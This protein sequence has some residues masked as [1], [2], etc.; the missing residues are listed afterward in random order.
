MAVPIV[1]TSG[2]QAGEP[3][4]IDNVLAR[5]HLGHIAEYFVLHNR[6]IAQRVDDS[7]VKV[8]LNVP[9]MFRRSRGYAPAPVTLPKG[10]E[11]GP[12]VLAM[13]GELK[14]T[15]CFLKKGQAFLSHHIG[16]LEEAL[17]YANYQRAL[18]Q[19]QQLFGLTPEVI[20]V[21]RHPEY[22]SSKLG[23]ERA[24]HA[25]LPVIEVQH[26]HAHLAACLADHGIPLMTSP[27]LGVILDGLGYGEDHTIWGGEFLA[28]DYHHVTRLGTFKPVAMLGGSQAIKEPWRNT[29]AHLV[30]GMGWAQFA[31]NYHGLPLFHYLEQ[32]PRSMLDQMLAKNVN[33]PLASSCG[34]LFDAVAAAMG[35]CQDRILYEGQAAMELEAMVNLATLELED[36][37]VAY[38]FSISPLRGFQPLC[39]E[40]LAMWE[41]FLGDLA[42]GTPRPVM[43]A[44]FHKGLANAI[45]AMVNICSQTSDSQRAY[46]TVALSGG[47]FQNKV[48]FELVH[49]KL[50]REGFTVLSHHEVPMND[51]G[52]ALGQ[53]V[54]AAAHSSYTSRLN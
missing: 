23:R 17:T 28:G 2:N 24:G 22:L 43:A 30:A 40:P 3:Q 21:D 38:S 51:G 46:H 8:M 47:V 31:M 37:D 32:K 14:N 50:S 7:V 15:F 5:E 44:R 13:G 20:A 33:S 34:R 35:I 25:K 16:D 36:E 53:A 26:H 10:F 42:L 11:R 12:E 6:G 19:Y 18:V 48:L 52:L 39:I 49:Q 54:V 45:C 9:R 27:V 29:Y 41:A 1:L 4:W